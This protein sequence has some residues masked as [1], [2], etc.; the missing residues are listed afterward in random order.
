MSLFK[1]YLFATVLAVAPISSAACQQIPASTASWQKASAAIPFKLYRGTR[2]VVPGTI[3]GRSVEFLLDSG[4]GVTTVDSVYA[5]EIGLPAGQKI[6]AQGAGGAVEAELVSGVTLAVGGVTL[7]NATVAVMDLSQVA[8]AIGRPIPVV[9]GRELFDNTVLTFN[10]DAAMLTIANPDGFVAPVNARALT[11]GRKDRL[12]TVEV[13]V[14]GL[15]PIPAFLDLGAGHALSLPQKYWSTRKELSG[16]RYGEGQ[17]GGVGGVHPTRNVIVPRVD[18]GG[19]TFADVPVVL[20]QGANHGAVTE[21]KVGINLLR[22]FRTTMDLGRNRLYL[23]PLSQ[24]VPFPRDRAGLRLD[25]EG[26]A[27]VAAQVAPQGPAAAAGIKAGDRIVAVDGH[28]VDANFY[29]SDQGD[30]SRRSAGTTI[31]LT[32]GDG[33]T[34]RF[35]LADFY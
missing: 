25:L 2:V 22:Q 13:S 19:E 1:T 3:N 7:S 34:V 9:L 10:W 28:K 33:R 20:G 8:K 4:A 31:A 5:R 21:A 14:A 15:P 16:L 18:F 23:E 32:L 35:Q 6:H 26:N 29:E 17:S 27:L 12:N 24:R 11:L 30:W